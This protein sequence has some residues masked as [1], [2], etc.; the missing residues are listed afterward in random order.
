M[1][2]IFIVKLAERLGFVPI[3][4]HNFDKFITFEELKNLLTKRMN[5]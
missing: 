4:T 2:K 1:S 5:F 3:G